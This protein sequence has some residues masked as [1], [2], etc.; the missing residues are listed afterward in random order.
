MGDIN[1]RTVDGLLSFSDYLKE[2]HFLG[3]NTVEG[4]KT[5]VKKVFEGVDGET[6]GSVEIDGLDLDS[7]L[8]RFQVAEGRNYK[9]DTIAVYGRRIR[10]AIEAQRH[11]VDT[12]QVPSFKTAGVKPASTGTETKP[13]RSRAGAATAGQADE[14]IADTTG[15]LVKFPFPLRIG[16]MAELRLPARG[17]DPKDTDR[18]CAFIR[19]LQF[20]EQRQ[21]PRGDN[22]EELAA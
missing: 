14:D 9:P 13:K 3:S 11:Y 19:A 7:Y 10:Q 17:L 5:A 20:E 22:D 21:L 4:W 12:G 1:S 8:R 16:V 15:Q 2:K 6:A 18:L